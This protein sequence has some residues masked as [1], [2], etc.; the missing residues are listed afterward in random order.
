MADF[1]GFINLNKPQGWS[2][3]DCV[4]RTR[5]LLNTRKVGHGG[6]LDP[7]ASGVLPIAVGRATRLIQYL[8]PQKAYRATVRFGVTTS[9]DDLEGD[10]LTERSAAHL[11]LGDIEALLSEFTGAL[12]QRPPMFSAVQ[13]GGKRLYNLARKGQQIE[14]P[15]RE[16]RVDQLTV[17]A[18]QGGQAPEL[19]LDIECGPGTYIRSLARDIGAALGTGATLAGLVRSHS[20]GFDL[21]NSVTL[22][23][24]E[25]AIAEDAFTPLPAKDAVGHLSAIALTPPL[26]KRWCMG[27]KLALNEPG[28][29]FEHHS[30]STGLDSLS[31]EMHEKPLRILCDQTFLG[32]GDIRLSSY[33]ESEGAVHSIL[34][35]RMVFTPA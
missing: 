4:A 17:V 33:G 15:M 27:Q 10:V 19:V 22:E 11:Q 13:V 31:S 2:S 21:D 32:I 14:V 28:I 35:P 30:D 20:N 24:M 34:A 18:W 5:R 25:S 1:S 23:K 26:A 9:T 29:T 6:T 7:L 16:V 8:P 3:H 12:S